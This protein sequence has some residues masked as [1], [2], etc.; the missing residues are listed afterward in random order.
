M[1]TRRYAIIKKDF[2]R[3][4]LNQDPDQRPSARSLLFHP[5]LFEVHSLKLLA[6]HVHVNTP[7]NINCIFK[8][9]RS[10][11]IKNIST[12]LQFVIV[13][14]NV[15]ILLFADYDTGKSWSVYISLF[16]FMPRVLLDFVLVYKRIVSL[17]LSSETSNKYPKTK[18][19]KLFYT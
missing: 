8:Y 3:K 5:V 18:I 14:M 11:I 1:A 16:T 17:R 4:C 7:G 9:L 15:S 19:C 13:V 12:K 10:C 6:A 2:I